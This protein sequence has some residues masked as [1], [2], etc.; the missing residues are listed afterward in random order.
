MLLG[1]AGVGGETATEPREDFL[2][3]PGLPSSPQQGTEK[4]KARGLGIT[5][6]FS[7]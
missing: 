1:R 3:G 7:A 4:D 2:G 5:G 6:P